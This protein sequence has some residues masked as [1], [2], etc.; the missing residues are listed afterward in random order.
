MVEKVEG[1]EFNSL[2]V[3][4]LAKIPLIEIVTPRRMEV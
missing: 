2:D 3:V 1:R 4:I